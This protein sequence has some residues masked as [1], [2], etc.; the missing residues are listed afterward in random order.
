LTIEFWFDFSS[1]YAYFASLGI[2]AV[3]EKHGRTISWRPFLLGR[4]FQTTGMQPLT[5]TPLR[6]DYARHDWA[7]AA[8]RFGVAFRIPSVHPI[9]ST[10]P[11]RAMLWIEEN[12]RESAVPFAKAVFHALYVADADVRDPEVALRLAAEC[13]IG[14]VDALRRALPSPDL[15]HRFRAQTEAAMARGVFGSP[16][17]FVDGEPFWGSDR[18]PQIDEWLTKGGW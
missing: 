12:Q 17:F 18:L 15:K 2:D 3:A 14:D 7:R 9:I 1:P 10:V 6:G 5:H 8:R 13:G 16:F 4:A 11:S